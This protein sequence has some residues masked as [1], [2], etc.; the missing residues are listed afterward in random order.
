MQNFGFHEAYSFHLMG[1]SR[2]K[3]TQGVEESSKH[4][5]SYLMTIL[6]HWTIT[7]LHTVFSIGYLMCNCTCNLGAQQIKICI[8]MQCHTQSFFG[9]TDTYIH[10]EL[11]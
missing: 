4:D 1:Y 7:S 5:E 10:C 2:K 3:Q 9:H 8:H 11:D 6:K